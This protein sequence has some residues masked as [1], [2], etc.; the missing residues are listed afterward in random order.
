M[1]T[2][3][4]D[5]V[6]RR[7]GLMLLRCIGLAERWMAS[8]Q[9]ALLTTDACRQTDLWNQADVNDAEILSFDTK[10]KLTECFDERHTFNITDRST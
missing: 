2:K 1:S 8:S 7:F 10:L 3:F 6:L 9:H 4:L 5:A